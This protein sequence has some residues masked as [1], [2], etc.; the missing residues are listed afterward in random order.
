MSYVKVI[1]K[2]QSETKFAARTLKSI[3]DHL[4]FK[5]NFIILKSGSKNLLI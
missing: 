2:L 5:F 1:I 3:S 4:S